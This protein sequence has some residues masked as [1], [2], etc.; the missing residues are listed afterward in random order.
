M[1]KFSSYDEMMLELKGYPT[2]GGGRNYNMYTEYM[3]YADVL[4]SLVDLK[5][6]HITWS[7]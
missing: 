3:L 4:T 5:S 6:M 7:M 2:S 1:L